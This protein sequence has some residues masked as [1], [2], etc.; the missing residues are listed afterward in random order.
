MT[1]TEISNEFDISYNSIAGASAPGIDVY[2]KSV[3]LTK[4]QLEIVKNYYDAISNR[5]QKGFESTEKRRVDL[6]GLIKDYKTNV[7]FTDLSAIHSNS[8]F[9]N[10]PSDTFLIIN[11]KVKVLS[12]QC[13]V[14]SIIEVNPV[15]HDEFN[16]EINN[17]FKNPDN[18][19]I[20]RM[21]I[22]NINSNKV[23]ELIT[24]LNS[25]GQLQYQLRYLKYPR[26]IILSDLS[27]DFP[28]ENLTIDGQ[29][30]PSTSELNEEIHREILDRAVTLALRDFK[31][32]GLES[33][34]QLDVRNE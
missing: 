15:T 31:P 33:K 23:V 8:R 30:L 29:F 16:V 14:N 25:S 34:V 18:S 10:I 2:E 20:W 32:E 3:Y 21:D 4:A 7:S 24:P 6:R 22:S 27:I 13:L 1:V 9:F 5:K 26:P 12:G 19:T 28:L 11:E 17:P